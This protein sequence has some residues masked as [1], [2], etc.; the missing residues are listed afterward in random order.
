MRKREILVSYSL[1]IIFV[2]LFKKTPSLSGYLSRFLVL[3]N[4]KNCDNFA[5]Q[6]IKNLQ[7]KI[8]N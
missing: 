6:G 5:F 1:I 7:S 8:F 4:D 3:Q 2:I